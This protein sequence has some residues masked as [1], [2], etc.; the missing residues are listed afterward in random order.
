MQI[1]EPAARPIPFTGER[2]LT[3]LVRSRRHLDAAVASLELAV[4]ILS[5]LGADGS[6][7][8][9]LEDVLGR[10]EEAGAALRSALPS[11]DGRALRSP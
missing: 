5:R 11:R 6:P 10:L 3:E 2:A 8:R 1:D 7:L 4:E 9:P